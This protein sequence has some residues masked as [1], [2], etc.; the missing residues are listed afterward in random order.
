MSERLIPYISG[1]VYYVS[2][3]KGHIISR[4]VTVAYSA[5]L[6]H[7]NNVVPIRKNGGKKLDDD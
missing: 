4:Q 6:A 7:R 5:T 3:S 2:F 1:S